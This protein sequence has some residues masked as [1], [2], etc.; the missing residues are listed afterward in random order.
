M[1]T[2]RDRPDR[3]RTPVTHSPPNAE[4]HRRALAAPVTHL[5]DFYIRSNFPPPDIDPETWTLAVR[6]LSGPEKRISLEELK[7]LGRVEQT[8]VLECAG[9]GRTLLDP[10][11]AGTPWTLG[12]VSTGRFAG[13]P[14]K[15]LLEHLGIN[16]DGAV[17]CLF[18]GAD[19]GDKAGWG[20]LTFERSLPVEAALAAP[21]GPLVAWEMNGEPLRLEHGAP[22]RLVVPRWYAV[23]SVK[24]IQRIALLAQPFSG[25]FQTDRYVYREAG[26]PDLPVRHLKCRALIL[27]PDPESVTTL[28]AGFH[29]LSGIAWSDRPIDRVTVSTDDGATWVEAKLSEQDGIA[30][31]RWNLDWNPRP[32]DYVL[33]ARAHHGETSQPLQQSWNEL[34]YGNNVVQRCPVRVVA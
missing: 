25:Y 11:V 15:I 4:T 9:N 12:G 7:R 3:D 5:D 26:Q 27:D 1:S 20:Q 8:L 32:G 14:L 33:I 28:K 24:W 22:V 29:T 30:P 13:V 19:Q 21:D 31:I 10:P 23:A 6:G 16:H 17:E 2:L 18:S 34:G